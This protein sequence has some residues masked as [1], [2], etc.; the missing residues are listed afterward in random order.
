MQ[1]PVRALACEADRIE[2]GDVGV[3]AARLIAAAV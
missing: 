2:K 3:A 1:P